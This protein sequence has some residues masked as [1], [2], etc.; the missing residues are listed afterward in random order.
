MEPTGETSLHGQLYYRMINVVQVN[1]P[2]IS[3]RP[4]RY[5]GEGDPPTT[6]LAEDEQTARREVLG[7]YINNDPDALPFKTWSEWR[8]LR[9][10]VQP[11]D[12]VADLRREDARIGFGITEDEVMARTRS[13]KSPLVARRL[14]ADGVQ[15]LLT[16]SAQS[17]PARK[18]ALVIFRENV[19]EDA[20][21]ITAWAR[22]STEQ[23]VKELEDMLREEGR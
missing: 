4:G 2:L 1:D 21:G 13:F 14:R 10:Y 12:R 22:V 18:L 23:M 7:W 17:R 20:V 6:Y 16:W 3:Y 8:M 11:L 15:G 5:H 19:P 9:V